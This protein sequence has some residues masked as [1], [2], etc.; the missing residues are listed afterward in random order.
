MLGRIP[1]ESLPAAPGP[2]AA[3]VWAADP[4]EVVAA[5][6]QVLDPKTPGTLVGRSIA[7]DDAQGQP[8]ATPRK[9][10][11]AAA[12]LEDDG[13]TLILVT[14]PH[15]RR[16]LYRPPI[17][18][19]AAYTLNGVQADWGEPDDPP[20]NPRWSIWWPRLDFQ[21]VIQDVKASRRH[22]GLRERLAKPGR[23]VLGT[24]VTIPA[25]RATL[26]LETTGSIEDALWGDAQAEPLDDQKAPRHALDLTA[27]S[28]GE[29]LY[30]SI[31][32]KTGVD[33]IPFDLRATVRGEGSP[34]ARAIPA[35]NLLLPWAPPPAP[36]PA[37][38]AEKTP[39]LEG[40]DAVR[41]RTLFFGD[42]AKC[43]QC[44]AHGGKGGAVGPDLTH[45]RRLDRAWIYQSI[46]TP[47]VS[48]EPEYTTYTV[49][50]KDGQVHS[51]VVRAI[52]ASTLQVV[53]SNAHPAVI[54]RDQILRLQPSATSIM[55]VGL[56]A[57]L[58]EPAVRDLIAFLM[59]TAK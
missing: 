6:D 5:F 24:L 30:L 37:A 27:E 52:D 17:P 41:G 21:G 9:L 47:S 54:K 10:R 34:A 11:I 58:G 31:M 46:A 42:Q 1:P 16:A 7:Y 19:A 53:D 38:V 49:A 40:G 51:G 57:A 39:P 23:L 3:V 8:K 12:R 14:D 22:A 33:K 4:L 44:H 36:S 59:E 45:P 25:G 32:I 2:R 55:P 50:L 26:H 20:E 13:H 35:G 29:P 43:S 28:R 15:P 18:G 56:A 48:I